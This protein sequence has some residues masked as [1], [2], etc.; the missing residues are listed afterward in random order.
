MNIDSYAEIAP[1]FAGLEMLAVIQAVIQADFQVLYLH[2]KG[3]SPKWYGDTTQVTVWEVEQSHKNEYHPTQKPDSF[4][5]ISRKW[6]NL[7]SL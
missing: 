2:K 1:R 3:N 4:R 7:N 5:L 6:L